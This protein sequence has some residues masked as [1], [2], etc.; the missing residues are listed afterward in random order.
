MN[1]MI[2]RRNHHHDTNNNNTKSSA[3]EGRDCEGD[4]H[5]DHE[6]QQQQLLLHQEQ[7]HAK[8]DDADDAEEG[9][10]LQKHKVRGKMVMSWSST[11]GRLLLLKPSWWPP[12]SPSSRVWRVL[13]TLVTA[14]VIIIFFIV[15]MFPSTQKPS[16][17]T[18]P[19]PFLI[20]LYYFLFFDPNKFNVICT[21]PRQATSYGSFLIRCVD[22]QTIV[23]TMVAT[24]AATTNYK[25]D[26]QQAEIQR[27]A[28]RRDNCFRKSTKFRKDKIEFH[29]MPHERMKNLWSRYKFDATISIKTPVPRLKRKEH[30]GKLFVDI[31]DA[32]EK[33][34]NEFPSDIYQVIVQNK[35]QGLDVFPNHTYH[36]IPHWFNS[37][38]LDMMTEVDDGP[39]FPIPS[40]TT[41]E[42]E[43]K[44]EEWRQQ[45]LSS[46][47]R[48]SRHPRNRR[49]LRMVTVW[50]N[51][52]QPC[53]CPAFSSPSTLR[54]NNI[55]YTCID[56][57]YNIEEWYSKYVGDGDRKP[58]G[59]IRD[60]KSSLLGPGYLYYKLY[61]ELADVLVVPMKRLNQ[62]KL[63]Y[64]N[65]QRAVSQMRSGIP[66][67]LEVGD[68]PGHVLQDFMQRY[69]Y[70]C[71]FGT[72]AAT[73][74][75][76]SSHRHQNN[77]TTTSDT[78]ITVNID[79][80]D[81]HQSTT[82]TATTNYWSFD[83]AAV[84]MY[85]NPL[86]RKQCQQE[87]LEIAKDYHPRR[88]AQTYLQVLGYLDDESGS[89]SG[90]GA[91]TNANR[92]P[93]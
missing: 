8:H 86:L 82:N 50:N 92:S 60:L 57:K 49:H 38:P 72:A 71:V 68:R 63:N 93:C 2:R 45:Q 80:D 79:N 56:E 4:F 74:T 29:L 84:E 33:T 58:L 77:A 19:Y 41:E 6:Q 28:I 89:G 17:L 32:Y 23:T 87:G 59:Y 14:A 40:I 20:N 35:Y 25:I 18:T 27:L 11:C 5:D 1:T 66:V 53:P 13:T 26:K 9:G 81:R 15:R 43:E 78:T 12:P 67:L 51:R 55:T 91:T 37:Y 31:V 34:S 76:S 85:R 62:Q 54:D 73:T 36:V 39:I 3:D 47:P 46:A 52:A 65:V 70:T 48:Q 7:Q 90:G 21:A 64:G 75:A 61:W 10:G 30:F 44:P 42:E 88:I 69:N 22:L 24:T 16:L 83:E